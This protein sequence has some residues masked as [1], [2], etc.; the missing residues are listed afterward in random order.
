MSA[1]RKLRRRQTK[2]QAVDNPAASYVQRVPVDA[3]VRFIPFGSP[4]AAAIDAYAKRVLQDL[5][6][7]LYDD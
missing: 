7:G 5:E 6:D 1:S 2:K 4:S 3:E